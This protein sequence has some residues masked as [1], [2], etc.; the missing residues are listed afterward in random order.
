MV[1]VFIKKR[2]NGETFTV[3][4]IRLDSTRLYFLLFEGNVDKR[5]LYVFKTDLSTIF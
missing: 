2:K 4:P 1:E 3:S 5:V